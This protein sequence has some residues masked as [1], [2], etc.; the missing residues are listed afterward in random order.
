WGTGCSPDG[1]T[2]HEQPPQSAWARGRTRR[3][4]WRGSSL[5]VAAT[6]LDCARSADRVV[7]GV[8]PFPGDPRSCDRDGLDGAG[9]DGRAADR[10]GSGGLLAFATRGAGRHRGL[11]ARRGYQDADARARYVRARLA[12]ARGRVCGFESCV[13]SG[14]MSAYEFID[15]SYDVIVVGAGGAGLR[16]TLGLAEAGL[17]TAC[18]TKLFPTRS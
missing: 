9:L 11:C 18:I 15:H 7:R 16:A 8:T 13:R 14:A 3:C 4:A 2:P 1:D 10:A 12:R 6:D 5:V 17:S